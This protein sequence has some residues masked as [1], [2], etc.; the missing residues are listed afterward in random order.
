MSQDTYRAARNTTITGRNGLDRRAF[1][2]TGAAGLAGAG[3][4]LGLGSGLHRAARAAQGA[5]EAGPSGRPTLHKT[6]EVDG[7]DIFW[8]RRP[9]CCCTVSR[10]PR[11]C[12]AT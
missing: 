10:L 9:S 2:T 6:V 5:S 7:L 12:S 11:R 1:L 4:G 8:T 3:A